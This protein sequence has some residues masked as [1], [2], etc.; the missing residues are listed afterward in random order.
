MKLARIKK[1]NTRFKVPYKLYEDDREIPE[2]FQLVAEDVYE[3]AF[4]YSVF[5]DGVFDYNQ[6]QKNGIIATIEG[7]PFIFVTDGPFIVEQI[8][9]ETKVDISNGHIFI[10]GIFALDRNS[11][12]KYEDMKIQFETRVKEDLLKQIQT[13]IKDLEESKKYLV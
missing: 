3:A 7:S 10:R 12:D 8:P 9:F 6:Q 2:E 13:N 5:E 11:L 1:S 4:Q